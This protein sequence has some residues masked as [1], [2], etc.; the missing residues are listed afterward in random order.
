MKLF[1]VGA[2]RQMSSASPLRLN[3]RESASETSAAQPT[4]FWPTTE[5]IRAR[6]SSSAERVILADRLMTRIGLAASLGRGES[7]LSPAG[8]AHQR[9]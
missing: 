7:H 5:T 9:R 2:T 8:E 6:R 3:R 1:K 4:S